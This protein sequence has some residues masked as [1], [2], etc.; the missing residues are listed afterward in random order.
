MLPTINILTDFQYLPLG[1][2]LCSEAAHIIMGLHMVALAKFHLQLATHSLSPAVAAI[3]CPMALKLFLGLR[4]FREEAV[5]ATRLFF[6]R[7]GQIAF[8]TQQPFAN[9]PRLER[10][11][12][13]L[14]QTVTSTRTTTPSDEDSELG[15]DTFHTLSMLSL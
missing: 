15:Q 8:N 2:L 12:R 4:L 6:F 1:N 14:Y 13:L 5:S 11:F 3:V 9:R 10:A 7:L